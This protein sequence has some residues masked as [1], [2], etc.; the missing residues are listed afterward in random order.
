VPAPKAVTY[1]VR[2]GDT[3]SA[4]ASRLHTTVA[5]LVSRNGIKDPDHIAVGQVLRL[6]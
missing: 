5:A 4:I 2:P 3:L 1:T 6:P